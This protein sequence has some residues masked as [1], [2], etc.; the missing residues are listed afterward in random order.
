V[1]PVNIGI[2]L[3]YAHLPANLV[4]LTVAAHTAD[5]NLVERLGSV[6]SPAV[7]TLN[8]KVS[9]IMFTPASAGHNANIWFSF[10][11]SNQLKP[12]D[13]V[14]LKLPGFTGPDKD[15]FPT[16]DMFPENAIT[17]AAWNSTSQQLL[18]RIS[19]Y[20]SSGELVWVRIDSSAEIVLPVSGV[21][22]KDKLVP[23]SVLFPHEQQITVSAVTSVGSLHLAPVAIVSPVGQIQ[24]SLS[25]VTFEPL[26]AGESIEI[27]VRIVALMDLSPGDMITLYLPGCTA[28]IFEHRESAVEFCIHTEGAACNATFNSNTSN[29]VMRICTFVAAGLPAVTRVPKSAGIRLPPSNSS[30][31]LSDPANRNIII[32]TDA[33]DGPIA[34]SPPL[35]I[36]RMPLV[37]A[38]NM[39][40]LEFGPLVECSDSRHQSANTGAGVGSGMSTRKWKC[41]KSMSLHV[42]LSR[43]LQ[44]NDEIFLALPGFSAHGGDGI[45]DQTNMSQYIET[46]SDWFPAGYNCYAVQASPA[47]SISDARFYKTNSTVRFRV[48]SP[49][50]NQRDFNKIKIKLFVGNESFSG[51]VPPSE[52]G[53]FKWQDP[54]SF[55]VELRALQIPI[56]APTPLD[57]LQMPFAGFSG[58]PEAEIVPSVD[59]KRFGLKLKFLPASNL[60]LGDAITWRFPGLF[61]NRW[62]QKGIFDDVNRYTQ[63][64]I[65]VSRGFSCKNVSRPHV[66]CS[67][68][69]STSG[70]MRNRTYAVQSFNWSTPN[71]TWNA[72]ETF[73]YKIVSNVLYTCHAGCFAI[74]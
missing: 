42:S 74:V 68:N 10:M 38:F 61:S 9:Q 21:A 30:V 28:T 43:N 54:K 65:T 14:A 27:T 35:T 55:T 60:V 26:R 8:W 58:S 4:H 62:G 3:P 24:H 18:Y 47:N 17:S 45:C 44:E 2:I 39:T 70:C 51:L 50:D 15:C 1:V 13:E 56:I 63:R 37:D 22:N 29:L 41:I 71:A 40:S 36:D 31:N 59:W 34:R 25:S 46:L 64:N 49:I 67:T 11:A 53:M 23:T 73:R 16:S 19:N 7:I 72:T 5:G 69:S 12:G 32:S 6:Q 52:N 48:L 66:N 20:V 57:Y 33:K